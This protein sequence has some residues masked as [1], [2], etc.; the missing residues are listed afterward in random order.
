MKALL[1]TLFLAVISLPLAANLAGVDGGDPDAESRELAAFHWDA[2]GVWFEDHFGFRATLIRWYGES[3]LFAL[4]VSPTTAV[5]KGR[6]G[7]LFY[8]DDSS[9][10]DFARVDPMTPDAVQNWRDAI[11]RTRDWLR[12]RGI[13]YV[14]TVAPDKHVIY[15]DELPPTIAPVGDVSRAD[16]L[17]T[18]LQDLGVAIDVRPA[19]REAGARERIYQRTDTHWNDRGALI[20]YQQII[21]AVRLRVPATPPA[22]SRGDFEAVDRDVPAMD[23]GRMIGLARV[24]RETDMTLVPRRPRRARVVEPAGAKPTDELGRIVT[25]IDDPSLPRAV[26][27]RDSFVSRLVP[28]LSEHFSR[29]VYVWENDFDADQVV[30]ER[31]DVVIQ[32]IVGRHLY[33]FIPS[34]ELVP[35][36]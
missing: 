7:W 26:I 1:V 24:L 11:V 2:P 8:A 13:P 32:E 20:A 9:I 27:F 29:A 4:G 18:A 14:F 30:R 34:P 15:P 36:K 35:E 16:Q 6:D 3:R 10:E 25:E 31:P 23:L 5:V 33:G 28:F 12:A 17:Y 21:A 22:W 19:L